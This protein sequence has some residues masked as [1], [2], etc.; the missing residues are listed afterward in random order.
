MPD[1]KYST[2]SKGHWRITSPSFFRFD[3]PFYFNDVDKVIYLDSDIL[4]INDISELYNI[5]IG[6]KKIRDDNKKADLSIHILV[7]R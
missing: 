6:C 5:D 2:S 1:G 3:I 4:V 7:G